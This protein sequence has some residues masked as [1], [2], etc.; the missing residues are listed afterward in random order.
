MDEKDKKIAS[1]EKEVKELKKH[2]GR[3][4]RGMASIEKKLNRIYHDHNNVAVKV[5]ALVA[6]QR[7]RR[8]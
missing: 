2:L 3:M 8:Q 5:H 1:L 7:S 6:G 4:G